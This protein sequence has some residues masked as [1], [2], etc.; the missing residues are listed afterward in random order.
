MTYVHVC[1]SLTYMLLLDLLIYV[2]NCCVDSSWYSSVQLF[3]NVVIFL[4]S[5]PRFDISSPRGSLASISTT[6]PLSSSSQTQCLYIKKYVANKRFDGI[7]SYSLSLLFV[8][9]RV[10]SKFWTSVGR[11][12]CLNDQEQL[13]QKFISAICHFSFKISIRSSDYTVIAK[14]CCYVKK[15]LNR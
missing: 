11:W 9:S 3:G 7:F 4:C 8:S 12:F 13:F 14:K 15:Y 5:T 2:C 1:N 10:K 6:C